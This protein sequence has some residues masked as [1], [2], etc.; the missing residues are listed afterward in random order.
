MRHPARATLAEIEA[1]WARLISHHHAAE[2]QG[3]AGRARWTLKAAA[4]AASPLTEIPRILRSDRLT[5]AR[6]RRLAFQA[7]V[8][9]RLFRARRMLAVMFRPAAHAGTARWNRPSSPIGQVSPAPGGGREGGVGRRAPTGAQGPRALRG[10][11]DSR[12][13][14]A[15][16]PPAES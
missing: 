13:A 5:S 1:K 6:E 14:T 15:L 16:R 7:L 2:A 3:L 10:E 12:S 4:L 8:A 9:V 11:D